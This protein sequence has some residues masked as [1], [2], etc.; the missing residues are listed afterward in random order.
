MARMIE[1]S[2]AEPGCRTYSYAE[3]VL[4]PGLIRVTET[5]DDRAA[6]DAHFASTH[7]AEWR[8]A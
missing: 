4:D 5:W 1:G 6:L 8:A 3:D 7:I 2:R